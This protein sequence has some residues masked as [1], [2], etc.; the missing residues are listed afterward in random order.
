MRARSSSALAF[1]PGD[2][3]AGV[4]HVV[5]RRVAHRVGGTL[6]RGDA[7]RDEQEGRGDAGD[8][9]CPAGSTRRA[10]RSSSCSGPFRSP[11]VRARAL[12]LPLPA[13]MRYVATFTRAPSLTVTMD[14][15]LREAPERGSVRNAH[16]RGSG[17]V[18]RIA[19]AHAGGG[20]DG[21][22][23]RRAPGIPAGLVFRADGRVCSCLGC[24]TARAAS[25]PSFS[26]LGHRPFTAAA[27]V[28]IPLGSPDRS[29]TIQYAWPCSAV[30]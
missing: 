28:R 10:S 14:A 7:R 8:E 24:C 5:P 16:S 25:A 9:R 23:T 22:R 20:A 13:R 3:I 6:G 27:R 15:R 2:V 26:G 12:R 18:T 19:P 4:E 1:A 30:G 29:T 17:T 21:R 11:S